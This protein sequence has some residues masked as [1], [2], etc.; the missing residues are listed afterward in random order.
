[1][2]GI[3]GSYLRSGLS[4]ATSSL[5]SERSRGLVDAVDLGLVRLEAALQARDHLGGRRRAHLDAHDVAEA[6]SAELALDRLEQVVGVVGDLEVGVARHAK[7]GSLEDL[8]TRE[9]RR[10][11]VSDD[12][13][14]RDVEAAAA[15]VEEARESLG[16]L[17]ACEARLAE[18]R[19]LREDREREREARDV[20]ERLVRARRRAV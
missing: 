10:E 18:V 1:M 3:H 16:D 14:Q 12:L 9:E 11:E 2:A 7:D 6:P 20:R 19:I 13:L 17:H 4:T 15:E 8:D 5:S